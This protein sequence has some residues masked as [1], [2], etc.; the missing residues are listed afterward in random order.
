MKRTGKFITAIALLGA[1]LFLSGCCGMFHHRH[2][3]NCDCQKKAECQKSGKD[4]PKSA[5]QGEAKPCCPEA[6][7]PAEGAQGK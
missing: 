2:G 4:C 6:A 5:T 1:L 3:G 7:K